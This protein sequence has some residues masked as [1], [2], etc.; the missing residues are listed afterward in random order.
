MKALLDIL[1]DNR[2]VPLETLR[3]CENALINFNFRTDGFDVNSQRTS[4]TPATTTTASTIVNPFLVSIGKIAQTDELNHVL[5]DMLGPPLHA[6]LGSDIT[7]PTMSERYQSDRVEYAEV[8]SSFVPDVLQGEI[9]RLHSHFKV[10]LDPAQPLD[11][12][13]RKSSISLICKLDDAL[14]PS[15]PPI[16]VTIPHSYPKVAPIYDD[17]MTAYY[18]TPFL[19]RVQESF[20]SRL[21]KMRP[22]F[23]LSQLLTAWEMSVR[24]ACTP[25]PGQIS[26]QAVVMGVNG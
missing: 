24:A 11:R 4:A 15:V 13:P 16:T 12:K 25:W 6:L 26:Q 7:L 14:L 21:S 10:T 17:D 20:S 2:R 18:T 8:E 23:T 22:R 1:D 19:Q 5:Q 9:A 3:K